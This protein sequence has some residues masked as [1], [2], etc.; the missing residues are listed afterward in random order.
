MASSDAHF[1]KKYSLL[2]PQDFQNIHYGIQLLL[3]EALSTGR[4][5]PNT[6]L[7]QFESTLSGV[8]IAIRSND[9]YPNDELFARIFGSIHRT[10]WQDCLLTREV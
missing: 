1:I 5:S 9:I 7:P 6:N 3:T 8:L 4:I 10:N 2:F